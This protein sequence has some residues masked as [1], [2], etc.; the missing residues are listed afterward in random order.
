MQGHIVSV[1]EVQNIAEKY[2][3]SAVQ[4]A[5]RWN[6]QHQ[7]ITIPKSITPERILENTQ[8]FDFKLS[9]TEMDLLDALDQGKRFGSNLASFNF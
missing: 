5:L 2:N 1:S 8:V 9:Q 4:I 3:K 7:V 6:L